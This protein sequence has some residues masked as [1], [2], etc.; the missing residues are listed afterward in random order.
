MKDFL[1]EDNSFYPFLG[2]ILEMKVVAQV[3]GQFEDFG[4]WDWRMNRFA[5]FL[6]RFLRCLFYSQRLVFKKW[7]EKNSAEIP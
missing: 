4:C 5:N 6:N 1:K 2:E 3:V 7:I